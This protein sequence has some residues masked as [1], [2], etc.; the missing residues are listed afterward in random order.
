MVRFKNPL[1][2]SDKIPNGGGWVLPTLDGL[3]LI[4]MG[5]AGVGVVWSLIDAVTSSTLSGLL[6]GLST[7]QL[8]EGMPDGV[9][10]TDVHGL[11]TVAAGLGY[12]L[13]WWLTGPAVGLLALL[14]LVSLRR[15]V[16]TARVGDPFIASNVRRI[17]ALGMLTVAYFLFAVARSFVAVAIQA[18]FDLGDSTAT[19]PLTP[20]AL[21]VILLALAEIWRRGVELREEQRLTV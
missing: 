4:G 12:R 8:T 13:A 15:V 9:V 14:G 1:S 10:L 6:I 17:R 20:I 19:L 3:L 5:A 7:T 21:V 18:D 11:V 2:T 16:V